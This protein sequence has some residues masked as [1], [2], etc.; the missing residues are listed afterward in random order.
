MSP[1][2]YEPD[3]LNP[4]EVQAQ[5]HVL[6]FNMFVAQLTGAY[7][8]TDWLSLGLEVPIRA[9]MVTADFLDASGGDLPQFQSIHHRDE[10]LTG[11]ADP[12]VTTEWSLPINKLVPSLSASLTAGAS[13]PV[14]DTEPDPFLLGKLGKRHQHI[15]YGT[16]TIDPT[17]ALRLQMDLG[18]A[19]LMVSGRTRASMYRNTA[20]YKGPV[21]TETGLKAS[22]SLGID[23]WAFVLGP[24]LFHQTPATWG[25]RE[26]EN[27]GRTELLLAVGVVHRFDSGLSI[28][29][30]AKTPILTRSR[31][32]QLE[33]PFLGSLGLR[34][35]PP[36]QTTEA[37]DSPAQP[38]AP[39][40]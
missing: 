32:G 29:A 4:G 15:F 6:D 1:D 25:E 13:L 5:R 8:L 16:G 19:M 11:L 2:Q 40:P 23:G 33:I 37:P 24:E 14:G 9:T 30:S 28:Q 35:S 20:G 7:G 27:S 10:A 22:S 31:G 21:M 18:V 26:A 3:T 34:Y 17:L 39:A 36:L 38:G 12:T